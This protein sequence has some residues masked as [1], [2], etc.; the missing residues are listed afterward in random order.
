MYRLGA[1]TGVKKFNELGKRFRI[2]HVAISHFPIED[3]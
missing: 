2:G 1:D 3:N